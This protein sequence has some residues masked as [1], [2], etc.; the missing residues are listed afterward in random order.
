MINTRTKIALATPFEGAPSINIAS[1]IGASPKKPLLFLMKTSS[2][3]R[4]K[5]RGITKS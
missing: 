4:L 1:I 2:R 3:V 5:M